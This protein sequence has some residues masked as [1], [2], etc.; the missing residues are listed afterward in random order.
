MRRYRSSE[1][2]ITGGNQRQQILRAVGQGKNLRIMPVQNQEPKIRN[3]LKQERVSGAKLLCLYHLTSRML[4]PVC[5][6]T[7]GHIYPTKEV[8]TRK[9]L[10]SPFLTWALSETFASI[11]PAHQNGRTWHS[12]CA[13]HASITTKGKGLLFS[14][15][16]QSMKAQRKCM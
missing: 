10:I 7:E 13:D 5:N 2:I 8:S 12:I 4:K 14:T 6:T 16:G 9:T 15:D 1:G 3:S 11:P